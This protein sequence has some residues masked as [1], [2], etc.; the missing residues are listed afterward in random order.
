MEKEE[1]DI[2]IAQAAFQRWKDQG[3]KATTDGHPY[4]NRQDAFAIARVLLSW[5]DVKK[6][7]KFSSFKTVKDCVKWL[8]E[9]GRRTTWDVE[10]EAM[11]EG[12]GG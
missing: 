6:E 11:L 8:R 3:R 7:I 4:L 1:S 9:I 2:S 5:I 10:M 12:R